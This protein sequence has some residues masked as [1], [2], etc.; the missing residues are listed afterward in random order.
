MESFLQKELNFDS[1]K[2]TNYSGGG[3][4]N[5]G[6]SY[7]TDRGRFFLKYNKK[8][9]SH[10]MFK[11]EFLSLQAIENTNSIRVP[12]PVSVFENTPNGSAIL[13]EHLD[14][15]SLRSRE[16][17]LGTKLAQMH[18]HNIDTKEVSQFGFEDATCC[19]FI[20]LDNSWKDN[21]VSFYAQNRI[22]PQV[23]MLVKERGKSSVGDLNH[24]YQLLVRKM[25]QF[26]NDIE[27]NVTEEMLQ[28]FGICCGCS[29]GG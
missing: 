18:K 4:I 7:D 23:E 2:S 1:V 12:H 15:S 11:G 14:I 24:L 29:N 13:L 17:E 16:A 22:K 20:P 10:T 27:V 6:R 21:W 8:P 9:G 19:G 26:F 25:P 3:C 5:N 28:V